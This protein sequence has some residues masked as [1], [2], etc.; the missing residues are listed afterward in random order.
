MIIHHSRPPTTRRLTFRRETS[1]L[2]IWTFTFLALDEEVLR[3]PNGQVVAATWDDFAADAGGG[4]GLVVHLL[5]IEEVL[6]VEGNVLGI[7]LVDDRWVER[8]W[9]LWLRMG[10]LGGGGLQCDDL[11]DA[12]LWICTVL[13]QVSQISSQVFACTEDVWLSGT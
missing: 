9:W 5:G 13:K 10:H 4:D 1:H 8:I 2:D 6:V 7:E 12:H 11:R 3:R